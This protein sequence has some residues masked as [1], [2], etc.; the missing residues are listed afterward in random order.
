MNHTRAQHIR[1]ACNAFCNEVSTDG[2]VVNETIRRRLYRRA[3]REWTRHRVMPD[4][5]RMIIQIAR[6]GAA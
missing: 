2:R 5:R 3:K 6:E 1:R 4:L